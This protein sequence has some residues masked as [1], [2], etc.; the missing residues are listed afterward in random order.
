MEHGGEVAASDPT[1]AGYNHGDHVIADAL[2]YRMVKGNYQHR[3]VKQEDRVPVLS[4]AWRRQ[5]AEQAEKGEEAR[6]WL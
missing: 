2:C 1:A 4:L 6:M 5:L 3:T